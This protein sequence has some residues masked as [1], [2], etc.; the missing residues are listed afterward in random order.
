M[1]LGYMRRHREWLK[2]ML[3][4]VVLAFILLYIPAFQAGPGGGPGEEVARVG[5]EKIT[6][7]EF[8]RAFSRQRDALR[9]QGVDPAMLEQLGVREEVLNGLIDGKLIVQEARRLGLA[10]DDEAVAAQIHREYQSRGGEF[11]GTDEIRRRLALQ[12]ISEDEKAEQVREQLLVQRLYAL[13]TDGVH[14]SDQDAEK[15]FRRS[16]EKVKVEYVA[17]DAA[18]FATRATAT[19]EEVAAR[20]QSRREAYRIPE[21]RVI[22]YLLLDAMALSKEVKVSDVDIRTYYEDHETQFQQ[23]D[24]ACARHIE[25]KVKQTADAPAGHTEEEARVLAQKLLDQVK[26]GADFAEVAKKSS[27]DPGTSSRGGDLGCG[28]PETWG[29]ELGQ[30]IFTLPVNQVSDL[31]RTQAHG[32]H[33]VQV[34]SRRQQG[35]QPLDSVKEGIRHILV[36]GKTRELAEERSSKIS[37]ALAKGESLEKAGQLYGLTVQKGA[38]IARGQR[39]PP[40]DSPDL[41][42]RAFTLKRGES[43]PEPFG[44][45][46]GWLFIDVLDIQA[47]RLPELAEVQ[48]RVR[49]DLQDEKARALARDKAVQLRAQAE[50]AGLDKAAVALGPGLVRKETT[51]PVTRGQSFGDLGT[52]QALEDAAFSLPVQGLSEALPSPGGY[53][54]L[55]VLEKTPFDPAAFAAQKAEVVSKLE[56]Q[57]K[58]QLFQAYI[59]RARDRFPIERRPEALRRL[60]G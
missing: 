26:G 28:G 50:G 33:I 23:P 22:G 20:F 40:L 59:E 19:D 43:N 7:G 17:V 38:P 29:P 56:Q 18:P 42:A 51:T 54:V 4:A 45:A 34:L 16:S 24:E 30:A 31:I 3:L 55:R 11:V 37:A 44:T 47:P 58:R 14:V 25:V 52:N 60:K 10:V 48:D 36:Q 35:V 21:R 12:G 13:V 32:F 8:D 9:E 15:E 57:Q 1:A 53:A 49:A 39:V 2:Y 46:Q 41:L 27:E 6:A 5:Q